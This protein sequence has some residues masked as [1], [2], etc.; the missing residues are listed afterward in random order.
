VLSPES[1][2]RVG[3][4]IVAAPNAYRAGVA[5]GLEA[6][7]ILADAYKS[8]FVRIPDREVCWLSTLREGLEDLP[9][10]EETFVENMMAVV[11]T[12]TFRPQDYELA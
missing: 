4:A 12:S 2:I 3:S 7:T 8:G 1:A 5:A 9:D 11:D 10:D 6:V